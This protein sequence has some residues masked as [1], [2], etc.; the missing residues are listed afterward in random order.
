MFHEINN[1][2]QKLDEKRVQNFV[3]ELFEENK[4]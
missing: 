3:S 1:V 4:R 2:G